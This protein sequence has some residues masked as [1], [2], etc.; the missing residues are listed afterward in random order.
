M[1]CVAEKSERGI[2]LLAKVLRCLT[3]IFN[4]L[5]RLQA[6]KLLHTISVRLIHVALI[7]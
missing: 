2:K 3:F 1:A 6:E 5:Y 7:P 4:D